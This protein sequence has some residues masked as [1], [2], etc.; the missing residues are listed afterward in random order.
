[1]AGA[2]FR[3]LL[4]ERKTRLGQKHDLSAGL[5]EATLFRIRGNAT[6]LVQGRFAPSSL[7]LKVFLSRWQQVANQ[8]T[9]ML[10][11]PAGCSE[12]SPVDT[13]RAWILNIDHERRASYRA[14]SFQRRVGVRRTE[15]YIIHCR[16]NG[17]SAM[18][19]LRE[20]DGSGWIRGE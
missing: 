16:R 8:Q 2:S 14:S 11:S 3:I 20:S 19:R 9:G 12:S 7:R 6:C 10:R 18:K 17:L 15:Y 4:H 1:M 13:S 5:D